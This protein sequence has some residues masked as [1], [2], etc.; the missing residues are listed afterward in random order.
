LAD[1]GSTIN[2]VTPAWRAASSPG[3][4][5]QTECSTQAWAVLGSVISLTSLSA[6]ALS[7]CDQAPRCECASITPGVTHLPR[8]STR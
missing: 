2:V 4:C 5:G 8:A 7:G 3:S 1:P 6:S